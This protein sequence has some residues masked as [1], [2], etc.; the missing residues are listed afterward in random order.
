M[1]AVA[2]AQLAFQMLTLL[3]KYLYRQSQYSKTLDGKCLALIAQ[4]IR[5]F[6]VNRKVGGSSPPQVETYSVSKNFGTYTRTSVRVSKKNAV[7]HPHLTFQMLILLKNTL[8]SI[9]A[10][11]VP[12]WMIVNII[13]SSL[14][15]RLCLAKIQIHCPKN[16]FS[17]SIIF[18][19][20]IFRYVLNGD[21]RTITHCTIWYRQISNIIRTLIG[22]KNVFHSDV[23]GASP[24]AAAP[25][26]SS[27]LT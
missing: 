20:Y 7:A 18:L 4:M 26:T 24:V 21:N 15:F 2:R 3:N 9:T 16:C 8:Y 1:N 6:G 14:N 17:V 23:V 25:A 22:N 11:M 10:I 5:A 19:R 27:F 13:A 12:H